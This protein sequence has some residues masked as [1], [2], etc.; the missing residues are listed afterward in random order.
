MSGLDDLMDWVVLDDELW[1][2]SGLGCLLGFMGLAGLRVFG[3]LGCLLR[4]NGLVVWVVLVDMVVCGIVSLDF[5]V[6][7]VSEI[8]A[9][10]YVAIE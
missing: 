5:A 10:L 6:R 9:I 7:A 3:R 4:F 2:L 1:F 8:L